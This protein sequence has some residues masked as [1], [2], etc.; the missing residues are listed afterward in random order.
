M[1]NA[2]RPYRCPWYPLVPVLYLPLPAF[3]LATM[4]V[5]QPIEA[6]AGA[7]FIGLGVVVYFV[8]LWFRGAD[9]SGGARADDGIQRIP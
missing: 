4:F 5:K 3:M 9:A 1:P 8:W 6:A 7:V 2:E